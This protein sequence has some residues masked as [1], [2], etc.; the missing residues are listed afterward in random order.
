MLFDRVCKKRA[1]VKVVVQQSR[2]FVVDPLHGFKAAH[3]VLNVM[4]HKAHHIN[5]PA[6][7]CVVH[8]VG[9]DDGFV[10]EHRGHGVGG[11]AQK[12]LTDDGHGHARRRHVF[13]HAKIQRAVFGNI[14][15][16]GQNAARHIR[17]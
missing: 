7:R 12:V 17:D 15:R 3:F 5:A 2:F 9:V 16:A 8:A 4:Q 6:R 11:M 13:L 14:G 10:V 1:G